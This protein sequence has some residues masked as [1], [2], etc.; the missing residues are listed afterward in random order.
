MPA[1]FG[2]RRL[3]SL[4]GSTE[5]ATYTV[6]TTGA[7]T[8]T[9]NSLAVSRDCVLDWGDGSQT[10]YA[11]GA[12][13]SRTHDYAGAGTWT[14]TIRDPLA[15]TTFD[16]RDNKVTLNSS[17]IKTLW[18]IKTFIAT[19][20]KAG[21][22][23]SIDVA[24]WQPTTFD[25]FSLPA[26]YAGTFNSIDVRNWRPTTFYLFSMPVGY[27]GTFNSA[28]VADWRPLEFQL[29]AMPIGYAGTFNSADVVAW[30]PTSFSLYSMPAG[31]AGTFNSADVAT[32]RPTTMRLLAMP[33]GYT[34]TFDNAD[35]ADWRPTSFLFHTMPV[36]TYTITITA[37]GFAAWST[38]LNSF[39]MQGNSLSQA[40]VNAIL[41]DLYQAAKVPRT[42]T[43][44]TINLGG[45]NA[46]PSGTY[47]AA[48]SCPVTSGTPG[49][50]IAHELVNDGCGA[51]FNKWTTV[52]VTA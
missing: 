29:L 47:Q 38:G 19:T 35:V 3:L 23:N 46:A 45:T 49:K 26:G 31:Y 10:V 39:Q 40:Q 16:I 24:A 5:V 2:H 34:G 42:A 52:T 17:A 27:A 43:G 33:A 44:G 25:L 11:G 36:A 41:W 32:W 4:T 13:A 7:A 8:H 37:N 6:T 51:G 20:L 30:L 1:H 18:N 50:E 9:I 48:A 12:A 21:T 28:D 14:V 22:F 15:V